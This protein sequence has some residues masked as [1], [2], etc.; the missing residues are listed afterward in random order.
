MDS[1]TDQKCDAEKVHQVISEVTMQFQKIQTTADENSRR[2]EGLASR[3]DELSGGSMNVR[4]RLEVLERRVGM[5]GQQR[6]SNLSYLRASLDQCIEDV[7]G[8][9]VFVGVPPSIRW[10]FSSQTQ[11]YLN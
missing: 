8:L 3:V 1:V 10:I 2:V 9:T 11:S 5:E 6:D 7:K 4:S